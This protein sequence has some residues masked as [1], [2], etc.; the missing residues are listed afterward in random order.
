MNEPDEVTL[1]NCCP[2]EIVDPYLPERPAAVAIARKAYGKPPA[3]LPIRWIGRIKVEKYHG[4]DTTGQ[5]YEVI[6]SAP[7]LLLNAGIDFLLDRIIGTSGT[8]FSNANARIC[9]GNGTTAPTGADTDLAGASKLRKAMDATFPSR[10]AE[11]L[12]FK[13]TFATT[14]ANFAW[15]EWGVANS[16]SGSLLL[17]RSVEAFGTKTSSDTWVATVTCTMAG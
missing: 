5:P 6:E 9:V 12:T 14:D 7:N 11:V 13:S 4:D 17:N 15:A 3:K 8:S 1:G 10:A 2:D 16:A